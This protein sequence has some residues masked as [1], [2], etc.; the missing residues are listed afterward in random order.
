MTAPSPRRPAPSAAQVREARALAMEQAVGTL[1]ARYPGRVPHDTVAALASDLCAE[2][3]HP[4]HVRAA[5][6]RMARAEEHYSEAAFW[7][8]YRALL[9]SRVTDA[10]QLAARNPRTSAQERAG[11]LTARLITRALMRDPRA[12]AAVPEADLTARQNRLRDALTAAIEG[13]PSVTDADLLA[14]FGR[15][16]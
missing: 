5:V 8:H 3:A 9:R 13:D 10:P 2:D 16:P 11:L 1:Q 4:E 14:R 12:F 6:S 7:S 15:T